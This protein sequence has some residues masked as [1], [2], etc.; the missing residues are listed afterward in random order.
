MS[1]RCDVPVR[2]GT[3]DARPKM[4]PC[5]HRLPCPTHTKEDSD[6]ERPAG[7]IDVEPTWSG[8][9]L[10]LLRILQDPHPNTGKETALLE[11]R[12]MARA[13]DAYRALQKKGEVP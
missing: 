4:L 10:P 12:K 5:G 7:F 1:A 6:S 9:L 8:L 13:A 2:C 3:V 11:L